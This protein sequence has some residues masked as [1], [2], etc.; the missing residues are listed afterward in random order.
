MR[1]NKNKLLETSQSSRSKIG[2]LMYVMEGWMKGI[3]GRSLISDLWLRQ[4]GI[5]LLL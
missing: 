5:L 1:D 4:R 2:T 3:E